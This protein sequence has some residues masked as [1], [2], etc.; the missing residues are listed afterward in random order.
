MIGLNCIKTC[1]DTVKAVTGMECEW[2]EDFMDKYTILC[3]V[4]HELRSD[5]IIIKDKINAMH[6]SFND[7]REKVGNT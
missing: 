7:I 2:F 3:N 1:G 6:S 5:N 4:I